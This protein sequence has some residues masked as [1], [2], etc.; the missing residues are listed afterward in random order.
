MWEVCS[1]FFQRVRR[2]GS[3]QVMAFTN[4][5]K[6]LF[7]VVN[8]HPSYFWICT[9]KKFIKIDVTKTNTRSQHLS[10]SQRGPNLL[11]GDQY[12]WFGYLICLHLDLLSSCVHVCLLISNKLG[13]YEN[14][15]ACIYMSLRI[16]IKANMLGFC[17]IWLVRV[18]ICFARCNARART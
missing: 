1:W 5:L 18:A 3:V 17:I 12:C 16:M 2:V 14:Y 10:G 11:W 8:M 6:F 9:T 4:T 15:K 13:N 7:K